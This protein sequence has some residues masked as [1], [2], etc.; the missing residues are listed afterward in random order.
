MKLRM[1][2]I[3][4]LSALKTTAFL[5]LGAM[6]SL[7]YAFDYPEEG[8]PSKGA[9]T[10]AENCARCHNMRSP[11]DLRDDQWITTAFHMRLRAGLTGQETRDVLTFL[12]GANSRVQE[13][14]LD[15][16]KPV[17]TGLPV[18]STDNSSTISGKHIYENSCVACHG[19]KGKGSLP[20]VPDFTDKNGR[21]AKKDSEL[22]SNIINGFQSP[23]ALMSMPPRGGN[24]Q[25]SDAE[26]SAVLEYMKATF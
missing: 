22:L 25:L 14:K 13:V 1:K 7:T 10:W 18:T 5:L 3:L 21:L 19:V 2:K 4:F 9:K 8:D 26:L 24:S 12:Q 15:T 6:A 20:G 11:S 23:G 17:V 16:P